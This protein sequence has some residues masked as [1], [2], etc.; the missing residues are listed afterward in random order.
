MGAGPEQWDDVA[1]VGAELGGE[2]V[3]LWASIRTH[4]EHGPAQ[5]LQ[6]VAIVTTYSWRSV[7]EKDNCL[8]V[9]T[10]R[11]RFAYEATELE[12]ELAPYPSLT[13]AEERYLI[14]QPHCRCVFVQP[15]IDRSDPDT[16]SIH[17]RVH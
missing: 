7:D 16:V 8:P 17:V 6:S 14:S 15:E 5:R 10:P 9:K 1:R 11:R 2:A 13:V 3:R 12:V 4:N